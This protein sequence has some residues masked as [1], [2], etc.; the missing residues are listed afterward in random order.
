MVAKAAAVKVAAVKVAAAKVVAA[1]AVAAPKGAL[2]ETPVTRAK[3][4]VMPDRETIAVIV[5]RPPREVNL[6]KA[7]QQTIGRSMPI[8]GA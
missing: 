5:L 8:S 6:Q 3:A 2:K 1:K 7:R 4:T